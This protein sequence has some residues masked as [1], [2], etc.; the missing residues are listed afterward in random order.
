MVQQANKKRRVTNVEVG[1]WVYLKIRPHRQTSMP[2][3]LHPK[4]SAR[5]FGPFRVIQKVGETTCKL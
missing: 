1:D 5:Y 4:P 2:T 3:R